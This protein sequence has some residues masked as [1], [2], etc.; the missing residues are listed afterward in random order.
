MTPAK[1]AHAER[2]LA[3]LEKQER[4]STCPCCDGDGEVGTGRM[5]HTVNS[6]TI[7]PPWEVTE[8]CAECNGS[9]WVEGDGD[10]D[11]QPDESQEWRDFD[12]EC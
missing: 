6:T 10:C 2:M 5:S 7:D 11:G 1:Q 3:H 12:P 9:G 4:R 8:K